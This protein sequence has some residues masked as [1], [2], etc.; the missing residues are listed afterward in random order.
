MGRNKVKRLK[1]L[2]ISAISTA[3]QSTISAPSSAD[4]PASTAIPRA[5]RRAK[6]SVVSRKVTQST[7][8][9]FHV[10]LKRQ[11]YLKRRLTSDSNADESAVLI[12]EE[13]AAIDQDIDALGGLDAYQIASTLGQSNERGGDSSK[14]LVRW[15]EEIGL[16]REAN[17]QGHRLRML[18]IGAL[19][20]TNYAASSRWIENTPIDLHSQHPD[21]LEEDFFKRTLPNS[22]EEAFDIVSCS[23][24]LNFVSTPAERGKMLELIH[25]QLKNES[26]NAFLFMVL[27]LPCLTNS[28]YVSLASFNELM[29][30]VGF[31]LEKEQWKLGGKVGYWLWRKC[32]S[33]Q[34]S[35]GKWRRKAILEDG[36]RRNNF[37]VILP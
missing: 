22:N 18:E 25:K 23:L 19:V 2:P 11:A 17:S 27:P 3:N 12:K 37:A 7:I 21:I 26:S 6:R 15:L 10:L 30:V 34:D 24:V 16:K 14:V 4:L 8:S 1:K 32:A 13:L 33:E 36:P 29:S 35:S 9:R 31:T 20:P 28:R 5:D